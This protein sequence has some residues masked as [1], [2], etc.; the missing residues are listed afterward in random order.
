VVAT[1]AK[2]QQEPQE[3]WFL[4]SVTAPLDLQSTDYIEALVEDK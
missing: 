1:V 4:T 3:P 2:A